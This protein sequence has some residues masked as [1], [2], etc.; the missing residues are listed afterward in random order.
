[1]EPEKVKELA[2]K[3]KNNTATQEEELALLKFLNQGIDELR[4]FVK[5]VMVEEKTNNIK[6]IWLFIFW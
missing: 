3:V 5:E 4:A 6:T 1:M 2:E